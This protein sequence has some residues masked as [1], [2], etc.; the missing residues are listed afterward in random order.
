MGSGP[1]RRGVTGGDEAARR[2]VDAAVTAHGGPTV[3]APGREA[4]VRFSA[5]GPAFALKGH[6]R[7]LGDLT[8]AVATTGQRVTLASYPRPGHRGVFDSGDVRV[9][10]DDGA[11]VAARRQSRADFRGPRRQ[12]RWDVLD[13]LY[14]TGAALWTYLAL[15]FVL[16]RDDVTVTALGPW[17]EGGERWQRLGVRFPAHLHTHS[18]E[19]VLYLDDAG[20]IRRHDYTAEA[21]GGW[22]RAAHYCR[23]HRRY[24]D[25]LAPARRRVHPRRP[26]G[27]PLT[28]VTLVRIDV[29]DIALHPAAG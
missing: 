21:F 3:W 15:P 4:V 19:Q 16:A 14:F 13:L 12:L 27:A 25:L 1:G 20:R 18:A 23:D 22:A 28:A 2:L 11:V 7:T 10:T 26:G 8:G 9:E 5:G 29:H 6:R 17:T 24:G